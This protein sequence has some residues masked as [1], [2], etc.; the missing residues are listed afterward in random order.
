ME[1]SLHR[2]LKKLYAGDDSQTEVVLGGYRID[3]VSGGRLIEIQHGS[4]SAI[5][6]KIVRWL[7]ATRCWSSNRSWLAS[8]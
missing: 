1:T 2:D 7:P 3:A 6:D 5:R 4:L 8:C